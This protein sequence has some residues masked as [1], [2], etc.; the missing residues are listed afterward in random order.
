MVLPRLNW[1]AT[2]SWNRPTASRVSSTRAS[3]LALLIAA[4]AGDVRYGPG[5]VSEVKPA[6]LVVS[7]PIPFRSAGRR[8][9]QPTR[10]DAYRCAVRWRTM[11]RNGSA[12]SC[13][14][15]AKITTAVSET[16]NRTPITMLPSTHAVP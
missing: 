10:L 2:A 16:S 7:Q 13:A 12:A 3:P 4:A 15:T 1:P 8:G 11:T 14:A 5:H 9:D 6:L